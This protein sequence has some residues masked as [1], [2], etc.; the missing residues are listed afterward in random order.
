MLR[1]IGGTTVGAV[2]SRERDHWVIASHADESIRR[3]CNRVA[4]RTDG[5]SRPLG[6]TEAGLRRLRPCRLG[7]CRTEKGCTQPGEH[8]GGH[9]RGGEEP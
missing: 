9:V 6:R 7:D 2:W 1:V 8:A 5:G 4:A 3:R